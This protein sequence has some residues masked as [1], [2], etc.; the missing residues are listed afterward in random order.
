MSLPTLT[1][2]GLWLVATLAVVVLIWGAIAWCSK[3][4][5]P[6]WATCNCEQQASLG[7]AIVRVRGVSGLE[8]SGVVVGKGVLLTAWHL[9]RGGGLGFIQS[10]QVSVDSDQ[11][12][13]WSCFRLKDKAGSVADAALCWGRYLKWPSQWETPYA[14]TPPP[15]APIGVTGFGKFHPLEKAECSGCCA[16]AGFLKSGRL[17]G[18][19]NEGMSHGQFVSEGQSGSLLNFR[20]LPRGTL[21]VGG[22]SGAPVYDQRV[23]PEKVVGVVHGSYT[24]CPGGDRYVSCGTLV[25][26]F[27]ADLKIVAT[28]QNLKVCGVTYHGKECT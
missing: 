21:A 17:A 10:C 4:R 1:R 15:G 5:Q 14:L 25:S 11:A 16:A 28:Q 26:S 22:D 20:G 8:G 3:E 7:N 24:V 2:V 18:V 19:C 9:V 6:N 12:V 27:V 13:R 23:S